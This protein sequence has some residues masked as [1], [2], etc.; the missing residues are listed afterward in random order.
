MLE[1]IKNFFRKGTSGFQNPQPWLKDVLGIRDTY[2]G[3]EVT[4]EGALAVSAVC[5]CM[6][7]LSESVASL[8]LFTFRHTENGKLKAPEHP[9][10]GILHDQPNDYQTSYTWRAQSMLHVLGWGNAYSV[11]ERDADGA[12]RKLWPLL[13]ESVA[14]KTDGGR[15][16][17]EYHRGGAKQTFPFEDV[18]HLRGPSLNGIMG[19]SVIG[20]A[21]QGVALAATQDQY[22]ASMFR[23]RA[24]PGVLLKMP[25]TPKDPGRIREDFDNIFAGAMNAGKTVLLYGGL[26]V[27]TVGFSAEDA[28]FLESRQF[29]VQEIARWFRVSPTMIGDL[30][31]STYSNSE[32]EQLSFLQHSLRPWLV[33]FESEINLK[34]FPARTQ[35]FCE[36][37]MSALQRADQATRYEAYSK[38]LTAGFL[39]V[40]D[41]RRW[42][43]LPEMPG[44]DTL[45]RPANMLPAVQEVS[46]G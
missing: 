4:P 12:P 28:Q 1:T 9:V 22:G 36:F 5:A 34:L 44:T 8:P 29:S 32:Q 11:I 39:T 18:L 6:R 15:I 30:S 16:E 2:A 43:N 35:F 14:V 41:V 27:V 10:Y 45:L 46:V 33:N 3:V 7:L 24:R 38:G 20:L 23:N 17:Y 37:D 13:P 21:R 42:E 40:A 25:T 31:R 19:L 26:D